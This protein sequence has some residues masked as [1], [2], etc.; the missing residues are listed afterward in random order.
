MTIS[1]R[2]RALVGASKEDI[3]TIN[4]LLK[5]VEKGD[6]AS[7][8]NLGD[9][10]ITPVQSHGDIPM[11]IV[12]FD[13]DA[14]S[15]DS[16]YAPVTL[17]STKSLALQ[18]WSTTGTNAGGYPLA[19]VRTYLNETIAPRFQSSIGIEHLAE[20]KKS[21][22]GPANT[23]NPQRTDPRST[24][25][26][27]DLVWL[28]SAREWG[29]TDRENSG[30]IYSSMIKNVAFR[31]LLRSTYKERTTTVDIILENGT[32]GTDYGI[33]TKRSCRVGICIK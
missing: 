28:P 30:P 7:K 29:R 19:T 10:I 15:D 23:V 5:S 26:S 31:Y 22:Y 18:Y 32:Y 24:L 25:W 17:V 1:D 33:G 9:I 8:Y 21:S 20:V 27:N 4:A 2:R 13:V 12:G 14:L 11:Q 16:G 6:Y 3:Y